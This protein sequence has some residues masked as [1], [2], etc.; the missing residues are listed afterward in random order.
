MSLDLHGLDLSYTR[1]H[2]Q[3]AVLSGVALSLAQEEVCCLL[4]P[5]GCG[6]STLLHCLAGIIK[7]QAGT[8]ILKGQALDPKLHQIALVP[9]QYGL[10]PWKTVRANLELPR[11]L[12]KRLISAEQSTQLLEI[13]GLSTLLERYPQ[14]LSGG[15]RQ[16]VALARAFLMRPDL[17]LL[18]E[19]FSA[20]DIIT[21]ERSRRLFLELWHTYPTPTVI[22]THSPEEALALSSRCLVLG[23]KPGRILY[24]L[25]TPILSELTEALR[26]SYEQI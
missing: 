11:R 14:Q 23:G 2:Q 19:A 9:Q 13:L 7:P 26:A 10:L 20:L 4:G 1:G 5:S 22:V 3:T 24:D 21:G 15:Q 17:M 6:K 16:R 18:D 8:I 25:H 12:G